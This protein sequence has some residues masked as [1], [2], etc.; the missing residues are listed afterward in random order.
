M[1]IRKKDCAGKFV[2]VM[3]TLCGDAC[4]TDENDK[5]F[6]NL[7]DTELDAFIDL[8]GDAVEMLKNHKES[9]TLAEYG[10]GV[11]EEE[12]IEMGKIHDGN[13]PQQMKDFLDKHPHCNYNDEF[14]QSALEVKIDGKRLWQF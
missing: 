12:L 4:A 13:D 14:I 10:G 5:P 9:E 8:F 2:I 11:T 6:P 3:D 7:F 1:K